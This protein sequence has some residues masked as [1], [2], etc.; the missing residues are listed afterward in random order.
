MQI[1][2]RSHTK[3]RFFQNL[4][5]AR[6]S[7]L[8]ISYEGILAEALNKAG[9]GERSPR[10]LLRRVHQS[11]ATRVVVFTERHFK[12]VAKELDLRPM[13][14]IWGVGGLERIMPDGK[15][16]LPRLDAHQLRGLADADDLVDRLGLRPWAEFKPGGSALRLIG[17]NSELASEMKRMIWR[18]WSL[19]A[20]LYGLELIEFGNTTEIRLPTRSRCEAIKTILH[21]TPADIPI[22]YLGSNHLDEIGFH[23]AKYRAFTVMVQEPPIESSA[24]LHLRSGAE[25]FQ[26]FQEWLIHCV[27]KPPLRDRS[28][29]L[30]PHSLG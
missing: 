18:E 30:L 14:E 22:A 25:L 5:R 29:S 1:A 11:A 19:I 23:V 17:M 27:T 10:E 4:H 21:E 3:H 24:N 6:S 8:I 28:G 7:V 26:F 20:R 2:D 13:P 12:P 9:D 16:D 15:Y